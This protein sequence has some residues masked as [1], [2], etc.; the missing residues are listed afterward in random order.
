MI[1]QYFREWGEACTYAKE[2]L[3]PFV[4]EMGREPWSALISIAVVC[5][6]IWSWIE[7]NR[8]TSN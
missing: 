5:L 3:P 4:Y 1:E 2:C 6:L 8:F 7:K